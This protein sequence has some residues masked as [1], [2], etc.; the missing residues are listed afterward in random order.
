MYWVRQK[1]GIACEQKG[2][3]KEGGGRKANGSTSSSLTASEKEGM[4][5]SRDVGDFPIYIGDNC[6][7]H[8]QV[9]KRVGTK[10]TINEINCVSGSAFDSIIM[11]FIHYCSESSE[12]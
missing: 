6:Y 12:N 3:E 1:K 2:R 5:Q 11:K 10:K 4:S 7:L 9:T 8:P